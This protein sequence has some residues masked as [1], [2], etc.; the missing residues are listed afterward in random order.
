[1]TLSLGSSM[2]KDGCPLS[3]KVVIKVVSIDRPTRWLS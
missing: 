2:F 1:M 3:E